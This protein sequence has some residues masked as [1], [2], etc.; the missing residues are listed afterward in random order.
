MATTSGKS[1]A[2]CSAANAALPSASTRQRPWRRCR[3]T[4]HRRTSSSPARPL[5]PAL[6]T[7]PPVLPKTLLTLS[8]ATCTRLTDSLWTFIS[9]LILYLHFWFKPWTID[10]FVRTRKT[11]SHRTRCT[12]KSWK[13]F[14]LLDSTLCNLNSRGQQHLSQQSHRTIKLYI[15]YITLLGRRTVHFVFFVFF[16]DNWLIMSNGFS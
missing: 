14:L 12:I 9:E 6:P 15:S 4:A 8:V 10:F 5:T 7:V 16:K 3:R 1:K 13:N 2:S 11:L